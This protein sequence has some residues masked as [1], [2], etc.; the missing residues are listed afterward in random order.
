MFSLG[1]EKTSCERT[2]AVTNYPHLIWVGK[3]WHTHRE[4]W[5]KG[6]VS[7]PRLS[8]K[9]KTFRLLIRGSH[10]SEPFTT[11]HYLHPLEHH[12]FPS[13]F[14]LLGPTGNLQHQECFTVQMLKKM[15]KK[16]KAIIWPITSAETLKGD[17]EE[18]TE[19]VFHH[20][21]SRNPSM[22]TSFQSQTWHWTSSLTALSR[23]VP[24]SLCVWIVYMW[25]KNI[26]LQCLVRLWYQLCCRRKVNISRPL[27]R[28]STGTINECYGPR[29]ITLWSTHYNSIYWGQSLMIHHE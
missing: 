19:A 4:W 1:K 6:I 17:Q 11:F 15:F 3:H 25:S 18:A 2:V 5:E 26:L 14:S 12:M 9:T 16:M 7:A 22:A 20:Q 21:P 24:P 29:R 8:E 10:P 23:L 13:H 27:N 28:H